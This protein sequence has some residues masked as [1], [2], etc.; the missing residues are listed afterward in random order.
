VPRSSRV[1]RRISAASWAISSAS[2]GVMSFHSAEVLLAHPLVRV[3]G[4]GVVGGAAGGDVGVKVVDVEE[5]PTGDAE[6]LQVARVVAVLDLAR[7]DAEASGGLLDPEHILI[8]RW[9]EFWHGWLLAI[10]SGE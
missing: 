5:E 3:G 8:R 2:V 7:A 6:A 1:R 4:G 9:R 10:R